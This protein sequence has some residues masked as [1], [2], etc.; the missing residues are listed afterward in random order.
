MFVSRFGGAFEANKLLTALFAIPLSIPLVLGVVVRR[1]RPW[2][3]V[4]A[5]AVG[6]S[7]GLVLHYH[8]EISWEAATLIVIGLTIAT[9]LLSGLVPSRNPRYRE[10]VDAFFARLSRPVGEDEKPV[11]EPGFRYALAVLLAIALGAAGVLFVAMGLPSVS[12][13]SGQ[14]A[15]GAGLVCVLLAIVVFRNRIAKTEGWQR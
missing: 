11:T 6:V 5:V 8:P 13:L 3:A 4:A 7:A 15:V 12:Q 14:L 2:G 9:L 1:P 10:R